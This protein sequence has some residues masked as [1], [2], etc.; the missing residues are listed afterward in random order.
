MSVRRR[1]LNDISDLDP[2]E[3][4]FICHI[5]NAPGSWLEAPV[6][7]K[8]LKKCQVY[9]LCQN[10]LLLDLAHLTFFF[11][12]LRILPRDFFSQLCP[13]QVPTRRNNQPF[14]PNGRCMLFVHESIIPTIGTKEKEKDD[15]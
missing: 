1:E 14:D 10:A 4:R 2:I 11:L 5:E 6:T 7:S 3:D 12:Q 15:D 13:A 9:R 8:V